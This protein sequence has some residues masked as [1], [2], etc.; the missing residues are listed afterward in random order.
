MK[1]SLR[2]YAKQADLIESARLPWGALSKPKR[3]EIFKHLFEQGG[4]TKPSQKRLVALAS[5]DDLCCPRLASL[6]PKIA[7][8]YCKIQGK[9]GVEHFVEASP[10]VSKKGN[11]H[12]L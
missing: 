3:K 8:Y 2:P 12:A 4:R 1:N 10:S 11:R 9:I 6:A 7:L 5:H